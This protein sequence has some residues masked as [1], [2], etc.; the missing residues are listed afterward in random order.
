M[1]T[2]S[3]LFEFEEDSGKK[4][5]EEF[6][7]GKV[8]GAFRFNQLFLINEKGIS[9]VKSDAELDLVYKKQFI[10]AYEKIKDRD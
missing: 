2:N 10:N 9:A 3:C 4:R 1:H 7:C 8:I 6:K 5:K